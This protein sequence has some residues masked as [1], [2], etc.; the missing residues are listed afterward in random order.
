MIVTL[1]QT[2][3]LNA[4]KIEG[5]YTTK[6]PTPPLPIAED[7]TSIVKNVAWVLISAITLVLIGW[8]LRKVYRLHCYRS[9][10]AHIFWPCWMKRLY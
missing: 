7:N 8:I 6:A 4:L 9:S 5:L 3:P 1:S 2:K 10:V